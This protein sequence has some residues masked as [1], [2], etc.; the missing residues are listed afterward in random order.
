METLFAEASQ[1][2]VENIILQQD[3]SDICYVIYTSGSTGL[4][5]GVLLEHQSAV[6]GLAAFPSLPNLRQLLFHNPVF[7]AAQRSIWSTLKQGGCLCIASQDDLTV[8]ITST[9]NSLQINVIDVTPSTASLIT[10]G[11]V[12]TLSRMAVAGEL[13][14]PALLPVWMHRLELL[15]AY[16]L[17]ECTQINWRQHMSNHRNPQNVGRPSDTTSSYVLHPGSTQLCPTLVPGEL[18]RGGSQLARAYL[19]RPEKTAENFIPNPFGPG[20]LYRTGDMV[21][22]QPDGSVEMVGR[23][24]FQIKVNGQRV[25]PGESNALMQLHPNVLNAATVSIKT[26]NRK[27]LVAVISP[28]SGVTWT[29]LQR[30]LQ[31]LLSSQLPRYMIPSFWLLYEQIPLNVNGKIDVVV[32]QE[33][34]QQLYETGELHVSDPTD[35]QTK[36]RDMTPDETA[37]CTII[38]DRLGICEKHISLDQTFLSM[39]GSSLEAI[40][41]ASDAR[42]IAFME[43]SLHDLL[44]DLTLDKVLSCSSYIADNSSPVPS[45]F[46][47][48]GA[49]FF[50]GSNHIEDAYPV[51]PLQE[52]LLAD[53]ATGSTTY[54]YRRAFQHKGYTVS[55]VKTAF[56][57][58]AKREPLLRTQFLRLK[59][60]FYHVVCKTSAIEW[61]ESSL[62]HSDYLR[63]VPIAPMGLGESCFRITTLPDSIM[64][65]SAS[66]CLFDFWSNH[67][68][69]QD[70]SSL[71]EGQTTVPRAPY[72]KFIAWICNLDRQKSLKFWSNYLDGFKS[73]HVSLSTHCLECGSTISAKIDFDI[74]ASYSLNGLTIGSAVY[75]AWAIVLTQLF[76]TNDIV[77]GAILSGRDA[78]LDGILSMNGPTIC[79]GLLRFD[80]A[81]SSSMTEVMKHLRQKLSLVSHNSHW[82]LRSTLNTNK[83][84]DKTD[85]TF[86]NILTKVETDTRELA[87][88]EI[89]S[90]EPKDTGRITVEIVEHLRK[91]TLSSRLEA[92][93]AKAI[94]D[95]FLTALRLL[96]ASPKITLEVIQR[97][98]APAGDEALADQQRA[99]TGGLAFTALLSNVEHRPE[100]F[101]LKS[102]SEQLT[103]R[104]LAVLVYAFA[105]YLQGKGV[106]RGEIVPLMMEK[107]FDTVVV[108]YGILLAGAAFTALDPKNPIA[109]NRFIIEDTKA[110][111]V[112]TDSTNSILLGN[113]CCEVIVYAGLEISPVAKFSSISDPD[114][115][116]YVSYTSGST[117]SPKGVLI[118][119][120]SLSSVIGEMVKLFERQPC[121][122]MLWVLNY[123]FDGTYFDLFG[124]IATGG[125]LCISSQDHTMSN[126][127]ILVNKFGITHLALTPSIAKLLHLGRMPTLKLLLLGAEVVPPTFYTDWV[128][129]IEVHN[130][131][132]P[133]ELTVMISSKRISAGDNRLSVGRPL[134]HVNVSIRHLE[135]MQVLPFGEVGE[136][137]ATGSQV[138]QGYLKRPDAT[139]L[140]FKPTE[141]GEKMYRTGDLAR[142]LPNGELELLGRKDTKVKIN[143]YR[144]E[145]AEVEQAI[146]R[147]G[148]FQ[149]AVVACATLMKKQTL[150]A[151]CV[152]ALQ[153]DLDTL[154]LPADQL[155]TL[156]VDTAR[157]RLISL[158]HC[159]TPGLWIPVSAI[160]LL[161]SGKTNHRLLVSEL[162]A[163]GVDTLATYFGSDSQQCVGEVNDEKERTLQ[164]IWSSLFDMPLE[165]IGTKSKFN[166]LGGDS[167]S[168][169]GVIAELRDYGYKLDVADI[170]ANSLLSL[171]AALMVVA[172]P[173]QLEL[174]EPT[175]EAPENV[176][177]RLG[178]AGLTRD[179]IE[180]IHPCGP[181]QVEFLTQGVKKPQYWQLMTKRRLPNDFD[182]N[183][184][185]DLTTRLTASNPILRATYICSSADDPLTYLQVVLKRPALD[186]EFLTYSNEDEMQHQIDSIWDQFF[187]LA[188]P[189]VRYRLLTSRIDDS[190]TLVIKLD[191]ASYDATFR[192]FDAQFTASDVGQPH[193]LHTDFQT[194]ATHCSASDKAT[195]LSFWSNLLDNHAFTL[196]SELEDPHTTALAHGLLSSELGLDARAA[197]CKVT[198]PILFQTAYTLLLS[199]LSSGA[200]DIVYDNLITGR[201]VEL[202]NPGSINGACA[203]FLPFRS[204]LDL[205][206]SI[207][208][209]LQDTQTRFWHTAGNGM[210]SLGEIYREECLK[211]LQRARALFCFQPFDP[212]P[213]AQDGIQPNHMRWVVMRMSESTM[214]F[215]YAIMMEIFKTHEVGA[216]RFKMQYDERLMDKQRAE[217]VAR[218][219][220]KIVGSLG[221]GGK[222]VSEVLD[223]I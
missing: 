210:V 220:E 121:R 111:L 78:P 144:I 205:E 20:R 72:N 31:D 52:S 17:S 137:R 148:V 88:Q 165:D 108:I 147:T 186:V 155:Q 211:N 73:R 92:G 154:I 65:I 110:R 182:F 42:K 190:R 218:K 126:I 180:T 34:I 79:T 22:V 5:K 40:H 208:A 14:N 204:S 175:W 15:N 69:V 71:L 74:S 94:L 198:T 6:S 166:A 62:A 156:Q 184:W 213:R 75:T 153:G 37:L 98:L 13:I 100:R 68:V 19:N 115:L 151:F 134:S 207:Q 91:V 81:R 174:V 169:I 157:Q 29:V 105:A 109:R 50:C 48:P 82:G 51:T 159:M 87:V 77:F 133:T 97:Q 56:E 189:H 84:V 170:V 28:A 161:P 18:C 202:P 36:L 158:A 152:V 199:Y 12:P 32:L 125:T 25:E 221:G 61:S 11:A 59:T 138:T 215:N 164:T 167:I 195:Q 43:I 60:S 128:P 7:S 58:L 55:E 150:V 183:R 124:C 27:R 193:E 113:I 57:I 95:N 214:Y 188:K 23:I 146:V 67:F 196:G 96:V 219:F 66:H 46:Q 119:H 145:L 89:Q 47:L 102:L 116:A 173:L 2:S 53:L 104:D 135:N 130:A 209:L 178:K 117:G 8:G 223:N 44:S 177:D 24:D 64:V 127:E 176:Y 143:G 39:G 49:A 131:Y 9:I 122:R 33:A 90:Q 194:L 191:H 112:V 107:S 3:P 4:P 171:Q 1:K 149:E 41:V 129:K 132:G 201:N 200:L 222:N 10:S 120:G 140:A 123:I 35:H 185:I 21:V 216:Y 162:E 118:T 206:G 101:A 217:E 212:P 63:S 54:V 103:Y 114:D 141:S 142:W 203:N 181:G 106:S 160:P 197:A 26:I 85:L 70:L 30:E 76:E 16:G 93:Q 80:M 139:A 136:L 192:L 172:Q 163:I 187:E 168:A 99:M 86:V 179:D 83:H 38:A 45:P